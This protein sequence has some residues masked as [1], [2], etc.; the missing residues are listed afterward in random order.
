ML[1][2]YSGTLKYLFIFNPLHQLCKVNRFYLREAF[3]H[4]VKMKLLSYSRYTVSKMTADFIFYLW[5]YTPKIT[6]SFKTFRPLAFVLY[7][8]K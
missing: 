5:K 4:S 3:Q 6:L 1:R 8:E 7:S 2:P